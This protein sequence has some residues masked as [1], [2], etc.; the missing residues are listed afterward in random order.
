MLRPLFVDA[1]GEKLVVLHLDVERRMIG[2]D[3]GPVDNE[4]SVLFPMRAIIGAALALDARGLVIA[5]N[6]PSGDPRPSRADIRATR[7]LAETAGALDIR[8]HDHL[9]FAGADCRSFRELGLL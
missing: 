2:L 1:G 3:E 7:R 4:D 5:H 6:H 9:I 8:L